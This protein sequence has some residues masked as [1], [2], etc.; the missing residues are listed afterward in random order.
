MKI[1]II[2]F[3]FVLFLFAAFGSANASIKINEFESNPLGT[4]T[5]NE[6]VELYNDG[7]F[8]VILADWRLVNSA[9]S[10]YLIPDGIIAAKGYWNH[11][12]SGGWLRNTNENITLFDSN[13]AFADSTI[14]VNDEQDSTKTWQRIPDGGNDWQFLEGTQGATNGGGSGG[15][16]PEFPSFIVPMLIVF[17]SIPMAARFA[18]I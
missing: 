4:D 16:I 1:N 17:L 11:T 18:R 10:S 12:F 3:A 2:N 7:D 6:W 8:E 5:G 14:T 13:D 9:G 15:G